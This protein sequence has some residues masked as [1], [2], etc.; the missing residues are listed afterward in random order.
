MSLGGEHL[1]GGIVLFRNA[2]DVPLQEVYEFLEN[3]KNEWRKENFEYVYDDNGTPL[4]AINK[5]GF[6]YSIEMANSAPVRIQDLQHKFFKACDTQ[7]YKCLLQYIERFPSILQC[8]WWYSGGHALAYDK[9]GSLGF[10]CDNDVNYRFGAFPKSEHA[11]RNVLSAVVYI[12]DCI[13]NDA[14]SEYSYSGGHM[15]FKYFGIDYIPKSGDI[16]LFPANYLG[17]HEIEEVT[18]GTRYSYLSFF[19]QGSEDSE[20]QISPMV[21]KNNWTP[22]GQWWLPTIIPDYEKYLIDK[23]NGEENVPDDMLGFRSRAYD[24]Q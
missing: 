18:D 14:H 6:I 19:A 22:G 12:N 20:L 10:H 2:I 15:T 13:D 23:Y 16:L 7:T 21:R 24:H 9:G 3:R 1:G 11:T 8:L 4:H 5:G 17:A